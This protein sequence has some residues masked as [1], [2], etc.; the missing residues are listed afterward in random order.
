MIGYLLDH[1]EQR[2]D[3]SLPSPKSQSPSAHPDD[4]NSSESPRNEQSK[5]NQIDDEKVDVDTNPRKKKRRNS[6][7]L[8]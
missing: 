4:G 5:D 7:C 8:F 1:L 3:E 2:A 6:M